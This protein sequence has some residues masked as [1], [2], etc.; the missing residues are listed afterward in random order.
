MS[1]NK[2]VYIDYVIMRTGYS[3]YSYTLTIEFNYFTN[4][5][6][7]YLKRRDKLS[8]EISRRCCMHYCYSLASRRQRRGLLT[9]TVETLNRLR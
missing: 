1:A 3:V 4:E 5:I 2:F 9:G 6:V 8:S 7:M